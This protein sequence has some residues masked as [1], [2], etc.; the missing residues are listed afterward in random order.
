MSGS[1]ASQQLLPHLLFQPLF[2]ASFLAFT[3]LSACAPLPAWRFSATEPAATLVPIQ[4]AGVRD[5]RRE[6]RDALC[7][8]N[9]RRGREYPDYRPCDK[10][11]YAPQG[12]LEAAQRP[13]PATADVPETPL[14]LVFVPGIFGECVQRHVTP[15]SDSYDALRARGHTVEYVPLSG[16]SGSAANA[17]VLRDGLQKIAASSG[18]VILV[19]YSKGTPDAMEMLVSYPETAGW[20]KALLSVAGVVSGTPLADTFTDLYE[21]LAASVPLSP[22][23]PGDGEEVRS[24]SRTVRLRWLAENKLPASV[25]YYSVVSFAPAAQISAPL[26]PFNRALNHMDPRNDGQVAASDAIIPGST[27]LAYVAADH[28]AV[29]LPFNSSRSPIKSFVDQNGFPRRVLIESLVEFVH[30]DLLRR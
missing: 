5:A 28:W 21:R 8:L 9:E 7:D 10:I 1:R 18:P 15:F 30:A 14:T 19:T 24:L 11:V 12:T 20:V 26:R 17:K 16:R 4:L 25:A 2:A 29:T 13:T 23:P 27:L 3:T 22:C 6:F